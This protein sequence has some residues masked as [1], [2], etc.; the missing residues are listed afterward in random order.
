MLVLGFGCRVFQP[1]LSTST[2]S[3]ML[4]ETM[5]TAGGEFFNDDPTPATTRPDN[6]EVSVPIPIKMRRATRRL[7][8][9]CCKSLLAR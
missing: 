3:V 6:V 5:E 7:L 2:K 8:N 1:A 9:F 4:L